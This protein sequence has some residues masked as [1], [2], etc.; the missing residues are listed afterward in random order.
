MKNL[1]L[2]FVIFIGAVVSSQAQDYNSAVGVRLGYP[3][4][5]SYKKFISENNALEVYGG[6]R[7][8]GTYSSI[9]VN[10]AF[11]LHK[12]IDS[13]ENLRWYWGLGAG[14][15]FYSF[16]FVTTEGATAITASVYGGLEYTLD[17]TP[18][19][20]S[21]DWAPTLFIGGFGSGFGASN[22]AL[23]VRYV[24]GGGND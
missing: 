6:F 7:G 8:Y 22:G 12:D 5:L 10:G 23:A 21:V 15:A 16:D 20:F 13:V 11:L 24:L 18:V 17:G 2:V 19:S 1:L 9:R 3:M 14:V 4:S